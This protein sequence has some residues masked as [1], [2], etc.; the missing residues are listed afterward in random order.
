MVWRKLITKSFSNF[1][2][3][4]R[5]GK[6]K[7]RDAAIIKMINLRQTVDKRLKKEKS[8]DHWPLFEVWQTTEAMIANAVEFVESL[9][10]DGWTE[11]ESV[12]KLLFRL[13]LP[14]DACPDLVSYLRFRLEAVDPE[15]LQFDI[16]DQVVAIAK[17][18]AQIE[19]KN[20]TS[21]VTYPPTEWLLNKISYDDMSPD[22][23]GNKD[24]IRIQL[25]MKPGDEIWVFST[26]SGIRS[27]WHVKG[28]ALI[29]QGVIVD[30][31]ITDKIHLYYGS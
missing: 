6:I 19:I 25:R 31:A 13:G 21:T 1:F 26:P 27:P 9:Q 28:L 4:V 29:R 14:Q 23:R 12:K 8:A 18:G 16:L 5:I 2:M 30:H 24:C 20:R 17:A 3:K 11:E 7:T 15:Y 10:R 22:Q